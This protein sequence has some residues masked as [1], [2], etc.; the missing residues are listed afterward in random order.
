MRQWVT[1]GALTA[2]AGAFLVLGLVRAEN[3]ALHADI[4][5]LRGSLADCKAAA[6]I[7]NEDAK[8]DA[9]FDPEN[10][11]AFDDLD[12]SDRLPSGED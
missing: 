2:L 11:P 9:K 8:R 1:I 10:L 5:K 6:N 7:R 3:E 12:P 4:A